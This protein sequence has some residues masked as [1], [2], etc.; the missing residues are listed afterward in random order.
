MLFFL[1]GL[2]IISMNDM[3]ILL[4]NGAH[5]LSTKKPSGALSGTRSSKLG[6][7]EPAIEYVMKCLF[8]ESCEVGN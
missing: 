1:T 6:L 8:K 2:L 4:M 5:V 7:M 3:K